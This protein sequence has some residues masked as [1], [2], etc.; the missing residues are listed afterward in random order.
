MLKNKFKLGIMGLLVIALIALIMAFILFLLRREA[1][2]ET[3]PEKIAGGDFSCY[4]GDYTYTD[5]G[6]STTISL[7]ENGVFTQGIGIASVKNFRN[8]GKPGKIERDGEIF[9]LTYV[10]YWNDDA[11]LGRGEHDF[12]YYLVPQGAEYEYQDFS[13]KTGELETRSTDITRVR[14]IDQNCDGCVSPRVYYRE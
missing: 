2:E 8:D 11:W 1:S 12:T 14:I 10:Y 3:C 5:R 6:Y 7:N 9:K 4:A 13:S